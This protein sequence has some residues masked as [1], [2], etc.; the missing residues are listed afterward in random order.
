MLP[1]VCLHL[2]RESAM[3][4]KMDHFQSTI[5]PRLH[6]SGDSQ[7]Q[8][9][10]T[11]RYLGNKITKT[12]LLRRLAR[13]LGRRRSGIPQTSTPA[14]EST[15]IIVHV[16]LAAFS[17][18]HYRSRIRITTSSMKTNRQFHFQEFHTKT[19]QALHR[20]A[21]FSTGVDC[22][23]GLRTVLELYF[24]YESPTCPEAQHAP[25]SPTYTHTTNKK[26]HDGVKLIINKS[27][28]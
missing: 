11:S 27:I 3:P 17:A 14:A 13:R 24:L 25:L 4:N 1:S 12:R 19:N 16:C 18:G 5:I 28:K 21:C 8:I 23:T 6:L 10:M 15:Q 7:L 26:A 2:I 20:E 22:T 9:K